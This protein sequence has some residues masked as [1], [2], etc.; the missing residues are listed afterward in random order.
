MPDFIAPYHAALLALVTLTLIVLFQSFVGAFLGFVKG[1]GTPGVHPQGGHDDPG[2]RALRCY[3]NS[4]ENLPAFAAAL[5]VAIFAGAG[6]GLINLLAVAHVGMRI[7]F[8]A[9]YYSGLGKPA[10]GPRSLAY[11]A[12][13]LVNIA[14]AGAAI[15]A[16]TKA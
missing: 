4:V 12:G 8:S 9:I 7:I 14:M 11:I 16:L 1:D 5:M 2:F 10:G 3:A 15:L 6:A 13:W